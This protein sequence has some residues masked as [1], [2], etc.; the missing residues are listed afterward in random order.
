[1]V[2]NSVMAI[3]FFKTAKNKKFNYK[4]VYYDAKK[5]EMEQKYGKSGKKSGE[6]GY[7]EELRERLQ[8]RW[9]RRS[10]TRDTRSSNRK[11]IL[12]IVGLAIVVYLLFFR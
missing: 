9:R 8:A 4:P 1:M 12:F 2:K 3:T 11:L 7:E 6:E 5:D 10:G